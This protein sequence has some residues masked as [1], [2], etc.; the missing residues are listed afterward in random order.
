MR[1][2]RSCRRHLERGRLNVRVRP[3]TR[4]ALPERLAV[5]LQRDVRAAVRARHALAR[6]GKFGNP[7][8][9]SVPVM[10]E[11]IL[12]RN[13]SVFRAVCEEMADEHGPTRTRHESNAGDK[14]PC[15]QYTF[16]RADVPRL[17][18]GHRLLDRRPKRRLVLSEG[19]EERPRLGLHNFPPSHELVWDLTV[20]AL[21][22][23]HTED[24][25]DL[26]ETRLNRR[27]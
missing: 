10:R 12:N 3:S 17:P 19:R 22:V 7:L 1:A 27:N 15:A 18:Q 26:L 16:L 6:A 13:E 25:V 24:P 4:F 20:R 2:R 21:T 9:Y 23:A 5:G 14:R 8:L 11:C